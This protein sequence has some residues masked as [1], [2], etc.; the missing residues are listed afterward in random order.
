MLNM[1]KSN[2]C[3]VGKTQKLS[4]FQNKPVYKP[5]LPSGTFFN[6]PKEE[7]ASTFFKQPINK[8]RI[9]EEISSKFGHGYAEVPDT[10]VEEYIEAK[11]DQNGFPKIINKRSK[12]GLGQL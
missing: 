3:G 12:P 4:D 7:K 8:N 1:A 10:F 9:L 5:S 2:H 6:Q 11:T